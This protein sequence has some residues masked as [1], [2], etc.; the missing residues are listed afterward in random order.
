MKATSLYPALAVIGLIIPWWFL[1]DFLVSGNATPILFVQNIFNNSVSSAVAADL[2]ISAF[3]FF[4]F[5]YM[6]GKR[7]GMRRL[8]VYPVVTVC[9][10]LSFGLPLFLYCRSRKMELCNG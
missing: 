9:I 4:V 1:F 5:V 2:L 6:E 3:V 7:W 10:G 8:W